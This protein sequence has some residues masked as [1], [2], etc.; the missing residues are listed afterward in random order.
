MNEVH[1]IF[2]MSH[3]F[4]ALKGYPKEGPEVPER[5]KIHREKDRH[6]PGTG[7]R[8]REKREG[9][10]RSNWGDPVKDALAAEQ[11]TFD[12]E[13]DLPL[14]VSDAVREVKPAE[15][16][17]DTE[18]EE[19]PR[20]AKEVV[21]VPPR[22]AGMVKTSGNVIVVEEEIQS[23][24]PKLVKEKPKTKANHPHESTPAVVQTTHNED[25]VV[26]YIGKKQ[27]RD[28]SYHAVQHNRKSTHPSG[29]SARLQ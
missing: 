13:D 15:L 3:L 2:K 29:Y 20:K 17:F 5:E 19:E 21:K 24:V 22:F 25:T 7:R 28:R 23:A 8:D 27:S 18:E 9:R 14:E 10:G 26:T 11:E 16:F 1:F 6:E 4:E 12:D